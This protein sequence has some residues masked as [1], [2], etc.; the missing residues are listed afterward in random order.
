[1]ANDCID[2]LRSIGIS[3]E[4]QSQVGGVAKR[5]WLTQKQQIDSYTFDSDGYLD[6]IVMG[7]LNPS[8]DYKL[9]TVTGKKYTHNGTF[10]GVVGANSN[11]IK[12]NAIVKIFTET[13]TQRDNVVKLFN[14]DELVVFFEN[15]NGKIEVYGFDKGLEASALAGATGVQ[16]Q[17]DTGITLTLSGDQTKLPYF[18]LNGG[19][20]ATSIAYLDAI[21]APVV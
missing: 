6:T 12:H 4:G 9:V 20:L 10:E 2:D 13:P 3:C 19:T 15:E 8:T 17:D 1:M 21:S 16:L 14:A 7:A 18:F 5:I 11:L